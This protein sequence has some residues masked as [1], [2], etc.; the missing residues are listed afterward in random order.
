MPTRT[1]LELKRA[2][3]LRRAP[4]P[5]DQISVHQVDDC[6][7]SFWRRLYSEV[8][9]QYHWVDRLVWTDD[10][11]RAY[12]AD[13]AVSLWILSVDGGVA[14][15]FELRRHADPVSPEPQAP[16]PDFSVEIAYFGLL[17]PYVG[18]GLGKYL[19]SEAA[20][21]AWELAPARVWLHTSTL[22]HP[23]AL[24]NYLARGFAVFK[25]EEY[26]L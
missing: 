6:A 16:G 17:P 22:D 4:A 20:A 14:G 1:Y 26:S 15:Y 19:L 13:P 5:S 23:S 9:A 3:D 18:R 24:P 2:E 8:G 21:R 7:P 25:I 11:I 10:D 12:L